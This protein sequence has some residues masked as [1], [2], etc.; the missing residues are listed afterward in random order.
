M[1]RYHEASSPRKA[2]LKSAE[3][4]KSLNS[5]HYSNYLPLYP[6]SNR[7]SS[8][9]R[10]SDNGRKDRD[11]DNSRGSADP[12]TG[13]RRATMRSKEHDDEEEQ[14]RRAL[15]ES[16]KEVDGAGAGKRSGKRAR[17]DND[18]TKTDIKRQR[19][20][21]ES[22]ISLS[23]NAT[24]DDDSDEDNPTAS[25]AKKARA[26]AVQL[27]RQVEL[28]EQERERE[29]A[30][31]DAAGRRQARAG[32]RRADEGDPLD[33]TSN[34]TGSGRTSPPPSSQPPSPPARTAPEKIPQKKGPGKKTKKLGNNQYTKQREL[35]NQGIASSPHSKKRQ[36][37]TTTGHASSG[38]EQLA[39]G[40]NTNNYH[41][42]NTS[43]STNKNSPGGPAAENGTHKA[44]AKTGKGK[45][46]FLNGVSS[47]KQPVA[48]ADLS[49][50][51]ME[52]RVDAMSAFMQRAQL[53]MAGYNNTA[54]A[55]GVG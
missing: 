38:D 16:K 27:A 39:N 28:R 35:A 49:L 30:R 21:S 15:E 40:S 52:R 53:E 29:R 3:A 36:L 44:P 33:E 18:D 17:E 26:D 42:A 1:A 8:L 12:T 5:Q 51:D 6:D 23:Q 25:R 32:R 50:A 20:T 9:S 31:A 22:A 24:V 7:K 13:R 47:S 54:A 48:L 55:V 46:K 43:H 4:N 14:L 37:A 10:T 11:A 2:A 45:Q 19:T 34:P 41:P